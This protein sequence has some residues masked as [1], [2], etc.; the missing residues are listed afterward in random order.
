MWRRGRE[1][2]FLF[3]CAYPLDF[4]LS[5]GK[6]RHLSLSKVFVD[7]SD[8][9]LHRLGIRQISPKYLRQIMVL[10]H[11]WGYCS[12]STGAASLL[13]ISGTLGGRRITSPGA[14]WRSLSLFC[15]FT[16]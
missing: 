16:V 3:D 13:A 5:N 8:C 7:L 10:A 2:R 15:S 1:S 14:Y 6:Q 9:R 11:I 4:M 12:I